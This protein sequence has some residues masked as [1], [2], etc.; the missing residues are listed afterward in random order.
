M[1]KVSSSLIGAN[2]TRKER[3]DANINQVH[4]GGFSVLPKDKFT[5]REKKKD[6]QIKQDERLN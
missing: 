6:F 5:L 1:W 2:S 3:F 4:K